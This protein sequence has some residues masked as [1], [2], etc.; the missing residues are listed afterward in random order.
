M[1]RKHFRNKVSWSQKETKTRSQEDSHRQK[2]TRNQLLENQTIR[3]INSK[4]QRQLGHDPI[5]IRSFSIQ[6]YMEQSNFHG[7]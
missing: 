5:V 6:K 7:M 2:K 3:K 4:S 1:K